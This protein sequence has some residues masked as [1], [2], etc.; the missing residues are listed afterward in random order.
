VL[1]WTWRVAFYAY[2]ANGTD[3]YPPFTLGDAP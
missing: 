1:R 3:R 2:S